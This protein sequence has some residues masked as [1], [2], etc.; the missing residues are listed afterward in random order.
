MAPKRQAITDVEIAREDR[1][2]NIKA[3]DSLA[4]ELSALQVSKK[5][6]QT[7]DSFF[8]GK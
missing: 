2:Q 7:L 6:Q 3:L 5:S 1:S 4:R 8:I